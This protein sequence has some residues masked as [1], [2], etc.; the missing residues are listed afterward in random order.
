[1]TDEKTEDTSPASM[2]KKTEP[3]PVPLATPAPVVTPLEPKKGPYTEAKKQK[4]APPSQGP[5]LEK[6]LENKPKAAD[7]KDPMVELLEEYQEFVTKVN[8][9]LS[10]KVKEMGS[11]AWNS[12]KDTQP[13]QTLAAALEEA[14]T[15]ISDKL[16]DTADGVKNSAPI[17]AVR[18]A[19]SAGKEKISGAWS[20]FANAAADK[21]AAAITPSKPSPQT[22]SD[23]SSAAKDSSKTESRSAIPL[24]QQPNPPSA[25]TMQA[26]AA[27]SLANVAEVE[28]SKTQSPSTTPSTT[29]TDAE[30]VKPAPGS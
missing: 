27:E 23:S 29:L 16:A 4:K 26:A 30:Q 18:G 25:Q 22:P 15:S 21:I 14:K 12:L 24:T 6:P 5:A 11:N 10:G 7:K 13:A 20:T 28:L 3:S 17:A 19:V 1:M 8:G 9:A 2:A